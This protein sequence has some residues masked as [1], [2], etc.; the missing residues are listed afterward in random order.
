MP[1]YWSPNRG[2]TGC[3]R[4]PPLAMAATAAAKIARDINPIADA[5]ARSAVDMNRR[6]R[7]QCGEVGA[8]FVDQVVHG[9]GE[10]TLAAMVADIVGQP[11]LVGDA[12]DRVP[13]DRREWMRP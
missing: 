12:G 10:E 5:A 2:A 13:R 6:Q 4:E 11:P 1:S 8:H 3:C 7:H 9:D